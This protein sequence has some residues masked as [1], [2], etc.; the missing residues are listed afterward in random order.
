M[1]THLLTSLLLLAASAP[2]QMLFEEYDPPSTLVVEETR[3][4][5]ARY[6]FVDVHNHQWTMPTDDL[7][8]TVAAMDALNMAVMVNLSG[9]AFNGTEEEASAHLHGCLENAKQNAPGRFLTFTN[10][11]YDG[12]EEP[13][14]GQRLADRVEADIDAGAAGLKIYKSLGMRITDAAGVRVAVDDPRL[15]PVWERCGQLDVPVLIHT[16]DPAPFWQPWDNQNERWF[17]LKQKPERKRD[18]ATEPSF[19]QLIAE[20]HHVFARHPG[21]TFISAHMGWMANDLEAMGR[22]LDRY[23]NVVTEIGAVLAEFGRQPRTAHA[24]LTKYQDRV[25]FGK[26]AW[27]PE[28]YHTYFRVLETDDEYFDYYRR[29]HAFWKMYGLDLSD[30]VLRKLYYGNALRL[31]PQIDRS[32]FPD[33]GVL[34]D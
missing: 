21:T 7:A 16:A 25:L 26:D 1:T 14:F 17:E 22:V 5:S 29:R 18:P 6:P 13:G 23:P 10:L 33:G 30:L 3:V 9:R 28:E 19:E 12:I 32:L 27:T 24:W 15:D 11:S 8:V 31:F 2:A 20:Q 34:P 4:T